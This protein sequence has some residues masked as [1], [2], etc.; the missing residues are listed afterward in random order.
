MSYVRRASRSSASS[1]AVRSPTYGPGQLVAYPSSGF[2]SAA[3]WSAPSSALWRR[4]RRHV[5]GPR[6]RGGRRDGHPG[7]WCDATDPS[8]A[9]SGARPAHRTGR[10]LSRIALNITVDL[11]DFALIDA[12]GMPGI[13]S[14]SIARS[15]DGP[16]RDPR[17]SPSKRRPGPSPGRSPPRSTPPLGRGLT[18]RWPA[19][20]SSFARTRS[21]AG[22]SPR[23]SIAAF[24]RDRFARAAERSTTGCSVARTAPPGNGVRTR[25]L[26]DFAFHVV[27]TDTEARELDRDHGLA[28]VSLAQARATGSAH[29]DRA[30]GRHRPLHAVGTDLIEGSWPERAMRSPRP[31]TIRRPS[32]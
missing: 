22:G 9:R 13:T 1:A 23:S 30:G 14:T 17:P 5:P 18:D 27:G 25:V 8:R 10:E 2:T 31:A 12:C 20:S 3:S 32:T 16:T 15:S 29:G 19:A 11:D 21:R 6:G 28:Q 4:P 26:K 7:C 24:H